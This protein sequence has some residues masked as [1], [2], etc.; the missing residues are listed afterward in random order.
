[1][2]LGFW[3]IDQYL[4]LSVNT[5]TSGTYDG[6]GNAVDADAE[7]AYRI[8]ED[9]TATPIA[10]GTLSKLDDANTLGFY[11]D[12]LQLTSAA[13]F[14]TGKSY[15]IY[16]S[17]AVS[18]V[19]M[20]SVKFFQVTVATAITPQQVRDAMLLASSGGS[21][22]A[23]SV[24]I[25]INGTYGRAGEP[26]S[27][28]ETEADPTLTGMLLAMAGKVDGSAAYDRTTDSLEALSDAE[29]GNVSMADM[30]NLLFKRNVTGRH[31]NGKP[32]IIQ[33]GD[34]DSLVEITTTLDTVEVEQIKTEVY[35]NI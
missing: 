19:V 32:R 10:T 8:Y 6:G 4:T 3:E 25:I 2:Y 14:E 30:K 15:T 35:S 34:G 27:L 20:T 1:M 26:I 17:Y 33:A 16:I 13:G 23:G 21:A 11:T 18:S 7:P 28:G 31:G 5:V 24:D 12:R 29:P 22:A 9:E